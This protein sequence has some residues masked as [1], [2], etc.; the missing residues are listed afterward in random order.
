M[1]VC[2][3]R[4]TFKGIQHP[5]HLQNDAESQISAMAYLDLIVR[6]VTEPGL[7]TVFVR[8]L[9]DAGKFDGQ[10]M[11]DVLVDRIG[12]MDSRVSGLFGLFATR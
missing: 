12:S 1:C 3:C 10:R 9:L 7:L 11:L 4:Q 8:F 5:S 2:V 6:S